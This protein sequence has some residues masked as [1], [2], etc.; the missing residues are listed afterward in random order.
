ML[1]QTNSRLDN[2]RWLVETIFPWVQDKPLD[3]ESWVSDCGTFRCLAGWMCVHPDAEERGFS[4]VEVKAITD[5]Y[6]IP[7]YKETLPDGDVVETIAFEGL[8]RAFGLNFEQATYVFGDEP[9]DLQLEDRLAFARA[10]LEEQLGVQ[11]VDK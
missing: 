11:I 10:C 7:I 8:C 9:L 5:G 3:F 1:M 6:L 2:L 4:L